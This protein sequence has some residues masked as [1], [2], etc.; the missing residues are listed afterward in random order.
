M[1]LTET[2]IGMWKQW[3]RDRVGTTHQA[4]SD[5]LADLALRGL[6]AQAGEAVSTDGWYRV[7]VTDRVGQVVA[8]EPEMLAGRDIG[9]AEEAAI[10]GAIAN[11]SG[12]IG[13]PPASPEP[14][15]Y[16]LTASNGNCRMWTRKQHELLAPED[17]ETVVALY[18][19]PT[20][21]EP[22]TERR[23]HNSA[24]AGNYV[25]AHG[26]DRREPGA[27]AVEI[28][29]LKIISHT[30]HALTWNAF[31]NAGNLPVGEYQVLALA[32]RQA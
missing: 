29:G 14:V 22:V 21:R 30:N 19:A 25:A 31:F 28:G 13:A 11:L 4:A 10:R 27:G 5:A 17:G 20:R 15:A 2:D 16:M 26:K 8:I 23:R 9:E 24:T 12:F 3:M 6:R 18:A 7:E 32:R 1:K